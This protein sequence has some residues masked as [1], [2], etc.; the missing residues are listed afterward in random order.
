[1]EPDQDE[2]G[3]SWTTGVELFPERR[4][5]LV[6]GAARRRGEPTIRLTARGYP[7]PKLQENLR[8]RDRAGEVPRPGRLRR[9]GRGGAAQP[10]RGRPRGDASAWPRGAT[11]GIIPRLTC[12]ASV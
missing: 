6:L 4:F 5:D 7:E 2:G 10:E 8:V 1:M 12:P 9:G 3:S 11:R